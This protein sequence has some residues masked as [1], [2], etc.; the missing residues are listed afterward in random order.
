MRPEDFMDDEDRAE[1]QESRK[2]VD[3]EDEMN[4]PDTGA[5]LGVENESVYRL[6]ASIATNIVPL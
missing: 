5:L 4:I 3:Q 2:L 1:L 6:S